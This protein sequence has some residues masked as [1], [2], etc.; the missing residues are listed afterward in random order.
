MKDSCMVRKYG[1]GSEKKGERARVR[2]SEKVRRH[3]RE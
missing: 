2:G 3:E 1:R